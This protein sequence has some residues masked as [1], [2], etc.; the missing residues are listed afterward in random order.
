MMAFRV[1]MRPRP[2]GFQTCWVQTLNFIANFSPTDPTFIATP[3]FA[4]FYGVLG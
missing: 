3:E 4:V 2:A 1:Y